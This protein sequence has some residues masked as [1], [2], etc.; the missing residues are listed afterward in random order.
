MPAPGISPQDGRIV[1]A[2]KECL[3]VCAKVEG[4]CHIG[5]GARE[6]FCHSNCSSEAD[7][8]RASCISGSGLPASVKMKIM[9]KKKGS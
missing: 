7:D 1:V 5:C 9:N 4:K 8:C 2:K 3:P 6:S